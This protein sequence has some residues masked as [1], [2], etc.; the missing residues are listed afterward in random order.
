MTRTA[1]LVPCLF[2]I[3]LPVLAHDPAGE[4]PPHLA[5][6]GHGEVR[7]APDE[8]QVRLGIEVQDATAR[9]AQQ[10]AN[11]VASGI[12]SAVGETGV[13]REDVQTAELMLFPV[14]AQ[15]EPEAEAR[16]PRI[17]AYRAS[18]VVTVRVRDLE[19][20][21]A[22][23][24]AGIRA[25]ANRIEGVD[26]RLRDDLAARDRAL[27]LAVAEA[28]RKA[29][30]L[31]AAAG[32]QLGEVL[33]LVESGTE[34]QPVFAQARA[35]EMDSLAVETPVAPGEIV[36]RADVALRYRVTTR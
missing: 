36:I 12:L 1:W 11:A 5:V 23:L 31:A 18:N 32:L 17:V 13:P 25:G 27:G 22:V 8:A 16:E 15:G 20:L 3:A 19:R 6:A 30:A 7:T 9:A 34:V 4:A 26:F 29:Q 21:G 35:I 24:D 10:R 33:A 28:R 14:H 2:T